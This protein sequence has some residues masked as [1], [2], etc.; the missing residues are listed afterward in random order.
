MIDAPSPIA[1]E[2]EAAA[3]FIHESLETW[4]NEGGAGG[5]PD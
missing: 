4:V 2:A 5:D 1:S 3:V